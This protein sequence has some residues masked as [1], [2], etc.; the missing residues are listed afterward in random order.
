M[1]S[2]DS[3]KLS[4]LMLQINSLM[5]DSVLFVKEKGS[6]EDFQDYRKLAGEVMGALG[7]VMNSIYAKHPQLRPKELG[8]AYYLNSDI[9]ADRFYEPSDPNAV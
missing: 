9:F 3:E 4:I 8:G 2:T 5:N 7:D 1:N 6:S